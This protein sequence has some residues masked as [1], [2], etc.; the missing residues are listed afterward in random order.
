MPDPFSIAGG[1]LSLTSTLIKVHQEHARDPKAAPGLADIMRTI[2]GAVFEATGRMIA[3]VNK[4]EKDCGKAGLDPKKTLDELKTDRGFWLT[5]RRRVIDNFTIRVT[6]IEQEIAVLFDDLVAISNCSESEAL[7]A[8][9][10]RQALELKQ[11]LRN[12]TSD[13]LPIRDIMTNLRDYAEKI[14][15][16]VGDLGRKKP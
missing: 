13:R 7:I 12:D 5:K 11:A 9:G 6:A 8:N 15:A 10:Y 14:R 2:P 4:L 16:D 1:A 3:E